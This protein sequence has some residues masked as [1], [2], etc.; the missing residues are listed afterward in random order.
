MA[1]KRRS[2]APTH[3]ARG[4]KASGRGGRAKKSAKK[5]SSRTRASPPSS[6]PCTSG[7]MEALVALSRVAKELGLRWYLFGAQ[8]AV[9]WGRARTTA[10]V[11]VTVDPR[12][13]ALWD[14]ARAGFH[15][16]AG[17][18]R[19]TLASSARDTGQS[20]TVTLPDRVL[21]AGAGAS[22]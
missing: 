2:G 5:I 4:S 10:D 13:L 14:S 1:S 19:V 20:V 15:V 16:A 8:A 22:H 6:A 21:P 17:A 3:S 12:L 18:Y 9:L 7:P 11:D